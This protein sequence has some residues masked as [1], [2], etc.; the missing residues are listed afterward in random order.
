MNK[1]F[2]LI[3]LIVAVFIFSVLAMIAGG[4]FVSTISLQ[5]RALNIK[6][7]E[8]NGRFILELM[9]R[10]I[11]VS[12]PINT[13]D[14]ACPGSFSPAININHPVNGNVVYSLV[15]GEIHRIVNGIDSV[16]SSPDVK[17]SRLN[18][19]ISGNAANDG[20]QPLVTVLLGL[21]AGEGTK[22][23]AALDLQTTVSQRLLSD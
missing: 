14:T 10:E 12:S 5:R 2:T 19:C 22:E 16:I 17:V 21:K 8:E 13:A 6:K 9:A 1:G 20:R 23:E 7:V 18:F 3:E 15:G 4:D 11:R